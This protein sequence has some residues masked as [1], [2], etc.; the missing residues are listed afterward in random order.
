VIT[1]IA[2]AATWALLP[3][4]RVGAFDTT[5]EK[6]SPLSIARGQTLQLNVANYEGPDTRPI[7]VEMA[8]LDADGSVLV[9]S[10]MIEVSGGH[11][12]SLLLDR[13]EIGGRA[14]D[15]LLTRAVVTAINQS[16]PHLL[17]SEE[18]IDNE[19]QRTVLLHPGISKG[20]LYQFHNND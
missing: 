17:V 14:G 19:T 6:P 16:H 4:G 20:L 13:D 8:I 18:V 9:R 2:V 7:P 11:T 1:L 5:D 10:E 12:V 3:I 15:R